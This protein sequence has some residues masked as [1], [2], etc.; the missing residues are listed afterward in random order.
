MYESGGPDGQGGMLGRWAPTGYVPPFIEQAEEIYR[1]KEALV[2]AEVLRQFEKSVMLQTLDS[3]WKDH[4]AAMDHLR[5]GIHLRGYA[6][7]N[8]NRITSYNVCYTKLL[9]G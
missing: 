2:G 5:Q 1:H 6:Q 4:L 9:R 8:P 3:L 7:K